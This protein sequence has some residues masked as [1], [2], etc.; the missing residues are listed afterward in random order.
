MSHLL[1]IVF[2]ATSITGLVV[3]L[4]E[5]RY[6]RRI[7]LMTLR[8]HE[9]A[10]RRRMAEFE[11]TKAS[12]DVIGHLFLV[13]IPA[14]VALSMLDMVARDSARAAIGLIIVTVPTIAMI[15]A[16]MVRTRR[17]RLLTEVQME[18]HQS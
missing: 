13:S 7:Y 14:V 4:I 3:Y 15:K 1:L 5:W 16:L 6:M 11:M 8:D 12:I 17:I 9:S 18:E 10:L 2:A